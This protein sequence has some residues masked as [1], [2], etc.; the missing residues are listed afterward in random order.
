V[1]RLHFRRRSLSLVAGLVLALGVFTAPASS[2]S[3]QP[4][5]LTPDRVLG[6]LNGALAW[7]QQARV[8]M[9]AVDAGTG[10]ADLREDRQTAVAILRTAFDFA[11]AQASALAMEPSA[12]P[13]ASEPAADDEKP[14]DF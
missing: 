8:A 7:Y 5:A 4:P 12:S 10:F 6:S 13:A 2:V 11:H 14:T 3:D 1:D 9:Q